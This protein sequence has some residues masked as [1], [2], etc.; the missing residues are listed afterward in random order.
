MI[1]LYKKYCDWID[2]SVYE[3]LTD[4]EYEELR[5]EHHEKYGLLD[6]LRPDAPPEAVEAWKEDCRLTKEAEAEG[7]ILD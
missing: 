1:D 5:E 3:G 7:K 6:V 4:E 2:E